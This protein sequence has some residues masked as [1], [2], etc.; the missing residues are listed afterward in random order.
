[1]VGGRTRRTLLFVWA[2]IPLFS[3]CN[4]ETDFAGTP[5]TQPPQNVGAATAAANQDDPSPEDHNEPAKNPRETPE[6]PV[7]S[8]KPVLLTRTWNAS[9]IARRELELDVNHGIYSESVV[10]IEDPPLLQRVRQIERP[11]LRETLRQGRPG[12]QRTER[13]IIT[14]SGKLDM[15]VVVDNSTSMDAETKNLAERLGDL[16]T[17]IAETDWQIGVVDMSDSCLRLGRTIRRDDPDREEAFRKAVLVDLKAGVVERGFPIAVRTLAGECNGEIKPWLRP[18]AALGVLVVSDEDNCGSN[19]GGNA[20]AGERGRTAQQFVDYL[21]SIRSADMARVYGIWWKPGD[22]SCRS[23]LGE[24]RIY[25]QA[26]NMTSGASGSI[27]DASFS[28]TLAAI[29]ANVARIIRREF[30]LGEIPDSGSVTLEIDGVQVASGWQLNGQKILLNGQT[31]AQL[32]VTYEYGSTPRLSRFTLNKVVDPQ[33]LSVKLDGAE[34]GRD[35][36]RIVG[37]GS[38]IEFASAP[39]DGATIELSYREDVPRLRRFAYAARDVLEPSVKVWVNGEAVTDLSVDSSGVEFGEAPPDGAQ[40]EISMRTESGRHKRYA[41]SPPRGGVG[42]D[43]RVSD[44][45]TGAELAAT[46]SGG[47]L[48][49]DGNDVAEGRQLRVEWDFGDALSLVDIPVGVVPLAGTI[50]AQ[51]AGI[52]QS[53]LDSVAFDEQSQRIRFSCGSEYIERVKISYEY[54]SQ[55]L[56]RIDLREIDPR[57]HCA[58]PGLQSWEVLV[59]RLP[60]E[61]VAVCRDHMVDL[62]AQQIPLGGIVT[63][64]L[65]MALP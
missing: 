17:Q 47:V 43:M 15:L 48:E 65:V 42:A 53:C 39:Q 38:E 10:M 14:E 41:A 51:G 36:W 29:S 16:T 57:L 54:V 32:V 31:G 13:F 52:S 11:W 24:A 44:V 5:S 46:F 62:D 12:S 55:R 49:F 4:A 63:L 30:E 22:R 21:R 3:G 60:F 6:L 19:N 20:C 18:D 27:C 59:D 64:K 37:A 34:L 9:E 26:V 33:T 28:G 50:V 40:V 23:A 58:A 45:K 2:A 8:I 35:D 7:E 1:M 56:E 25:Q 61:G